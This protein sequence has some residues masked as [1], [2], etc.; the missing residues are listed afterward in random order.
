MLSQKFQSKQT[1]QFFL[2]FAAFFGTTVRLFPLLKTNFPLV[3]GGMFYTMIQN[4][5]SSHFA[6]PNFTTY[7]QANIPFSYPPLAFYITG[8]INNITQ[9]S[10]VSLLKW[11]PMITNLLILP[12]LYLFA[13]QILHSENKAALSTLIFALTPNSYWW[14]IVGGGLTRALGALFFLLSALCVNNMYKLRKPSWILGTIIVESLAVLSHPEW[15]LQSVMVIFLF[16]FFRGRDRRGIQ[17]LLI[18]CAGIAL[19]TSPWWLT[20]VQRHGPG[21]FLQAS[22]ATKSR[23]LFW[24]IPLTM[25]F[26]G[27]Y[28]PVIAVLSFCGL[29]LHVAKKDF[30]L[31]TW[32]ML[33][34]FIDPRGGLPASV[35]PFSF[36]AMT[37]LSEG[38][39]SKLTSTH[40]DANADAWIYSFNTL[41]GRVFWGTF[42]IIFLYGAFQVSSTLAMQSLS[43]E[44]TKAIQWVSE[45]TNPKDRFL[46]MDWQDNPLLSPLMEWFPAL[47]NRKSITTVQGREWLAG[48]AGYKQQLDLTKNIHQCLYRDVQCLNL[49]NG[50]YNFILLSLKNLNGENYAIPLLLSLESSDNFSLVYTTPEIKIYKV[51]E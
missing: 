48:E 38:I 33:A 40:N 1:S 43:T 15:A 42:I 19:L 27:E 14:E 20:V 3:D 13:K 49:V 10:L 21:V 34:L 8:L 18:V 45:N 47:A 17:I 50:R 31:P 32:A 41:V 29:F 30:L 26:T 12:L 39:A 7:N 5:Q 6:L 25:G 36:L 51:I 37:T 16:W 11:Q 9:L 35:F 22:R 44:E 4:L 24:T 28:I 46:I 23:W 2:I